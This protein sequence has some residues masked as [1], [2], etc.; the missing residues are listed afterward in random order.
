MALLLKPARDGEKGIIVFTHKE[1]DL[2][3]VSMR[4]DERVLERLRKLSDRYFFGVHIGG[5]VPVY[6]VFDAL[7]FY[8]APESTR[9]VRPT[10]LAGKTLFSRK[11]DVLH[12]P[13]CARSFLPADFG[14]E[15]AHKQFDIIMIARAAVNKHLDRFF[16]AMK[17]IYSLGK[18]YKVLLIC[19]DPNVHSEG[20]VDVAALY[21]GTLSPRER[22]LFSMAY[23]SSRMSMFPLPSATISFLLR[24]SKVCALFSIAEGD[25]RNIHEALM[26]DI[27]V[28]VCRNMT[29]G[30]RD[31]LDETNSVQFEGFDDAHEALIEAV[32]RHASFRGIRAKIEPLCSEAHSIPRLEDY[33]EGL[34][35]SR[36]QAYTRGR[37]HSANLSLTLAAHTRERTP[38]GK[39]EDLLEPS[40]MLAWLDAAAT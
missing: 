3:S 16:A 26:A 36:G 33:L 2:G 4:K 40:R 7:D 12:I 15:P 34:F 18:E 24:S 23:L 30:A 13:L 14:T 1:V 35:N 38:D 11:A 21:Y 17:R 32:E 10:T 27:P 20:A 31:H 39:T 37:L 29:G 9:F 28:V 8:M 25:S 6:N 22:E 5:A 19:A